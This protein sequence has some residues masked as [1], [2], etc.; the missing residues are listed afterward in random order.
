MAP[1]ARAKDGDLN[2]MIMGET[3]VGKSTWINA[4]AN[5]LEFNTLEEAMKNKASDMKALIP[6]TFN[7]MQ[8]GQN[9]VITVGEQDENE[10]FAVGKSA[11]QKPKEYQLLVG[12]RTVNFIDTP[13]I[14]DTEGIEID[15]QNFDN[16]LTFISYYEK[17]HAVCI[18]VKPDQARLT[19]GFK[20][21]LLE[22][23]VHLHKSLIKNIIFCFTHTR[24]TFYTPGETFF[25][26]KALLSKHKLTFNFAP[27][28]NYFCFD[29]EAFKMLACVK[30]GVEIGQRNVKAYSESWAIAAEMTHK[31]IEQIKHLPAHDVKNTLS[32]N[33]A[34]IIC[35][36]LGK[37]IAEI[38]DVIQ[39]TSE[40]SKK[41]IEFI[42]CNDSDIKELKNLHF[43]EF[44]LETIPLDRPQ[45]VCAHQDCVE[46]VKVG[47]GR[48]NQ[49]H[50]KTICH[51]FCTIKDDGHS[52]TNNHYL[53]D[54]WAFYGLGL[55]GKACRVC[56]HNWKWH[57]HITYKTEL[58][59]QE[60]L[61]QS[62]KD[63]I[64]EK[65][66]VQ[67]QKN[68][69]LKQIRKKTEE[70]EE[71][72]KTLL[73]SAAKFATFMNSTALVATNDAFHE[74]LDTMIAY[75]EKEGMKDVLKI[76]RWKK[77]KENYDDQVRHLKEFLKTN[78]TTMNDPAEIFKIK[79]EL[80]RMKHF[81][82]RINEVLGKV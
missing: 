6:S 50:Y 44:R 64:K 25:S 30:N 57:M 60:F 13:G 52:G 70:L 15:R 80:G 4:I 8:K 56:E 62:V 71:E 41:V 45:N 81:G 53:K 31:M 77:N 78:A 29:N 10:K 18:L 32:M 59:E 22:L 28:K 9:Q 74:Y 37:P 58:V 48:Q 51:D 66:S 55:F 82:P 24:G 12:D 1:R 79:F 49:T 20:F 38:V 17:L 36:S 47:D 27:E 75:E 42:K 35:M 23:L 7:F 21:C 34:R 72:Q 5:Y 16:I 54:C 73:V 63:K 39:E 33:E 19:A 67:E 3:G 65:G 2:V 11:T 61:S 46:I 40:E 76:E 14:G 69:L 43:K 26:L 68:E